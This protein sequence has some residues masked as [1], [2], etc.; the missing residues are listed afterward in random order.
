MHACM[1]ARM[2]AEAAAGR[3]IIISHYHP[4]PHGYLCHVVNAAGH[5]HQLLQRVQAAGLRDELPRLG[6]QLGLHVVQLLVAR[7]GNEHR[8]ARDEE[9][10]ALISGRA[11]E[12]LFDLQRGLLV[13]GR[14]RNQ[15]EG[16]EPARVQVRAG[17]VEPR[18]ERRRLRHQHLQDLLRILRQLRKVHGHDLRGIVDHGHVEPLHGWPAAA[19]RPAEIG[20]AL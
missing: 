3:P 16:I 4:A 1:N 13:Q 17:A 12:V 6:Q 14:L 11:L 19:G 18:A 2:H 10:D 7:P 15:V 20:A 8:G 5:V 9:L